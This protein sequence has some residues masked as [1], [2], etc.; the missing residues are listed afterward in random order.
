MSSLDEGYSRAWGDGPE[1]ENIV[2]TVAK[3]L[4]NDLLHMFECHHR[5][6]SRASFNG[7]ILLRHGGIEGS[8]QTMTKAIGLVIGERESL[9]TQRKFLPVH[10]RG[11][12]YRSGGIMQYD[13]PRWEIKREIY[14]VHAHPGVHEP[15]DDDFADGYHVELVDR[16][17]L[18]PSW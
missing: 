11:F 15:V 4:P 8:V 2:D 16:G 3:L 9:I 12:P 1:H 7:A 18:S 13:K 17:M 10:I 6:L 5:Y 14:D